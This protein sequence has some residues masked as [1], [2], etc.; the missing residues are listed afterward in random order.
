MGERERVCVGGEPV[1][2]GWV[3]GG[4]WCD[5]HSDLA[6]LVL[7]VCV[8]ASWMGVLVELLLCGVGG[9]W[10]VGRCEIG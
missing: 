10:L 9:R 8:S 7:C 5:W 2:T 3:H 4:W 1:R 6:F